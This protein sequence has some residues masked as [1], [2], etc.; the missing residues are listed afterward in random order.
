MA[1]LGA[2]ATMIMALAFASPALAQVCRGPAPAVGA[3]VTGPV[4]HVIDGQ[5][6]CIAQGPT[7]DHWI[8]L[9]IASRLASL[10]ADRERLM[11]AAFS[12]ALTCQVTGDRGA[13]RSARCTLDGRPLDSLM[14]DPATLTQAATWR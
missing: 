7:P 13:T 3:V 1:R 5:T 14:T 2:L 9:T 4:L 8:P 10:P 6:L 11:A 12:R